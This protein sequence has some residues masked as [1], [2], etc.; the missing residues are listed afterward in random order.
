MH[1][2]LINRSGG[3]SLPRESVVRLTERSDMNFLFTVD[4]KQHNNY[5]IFN[6]QAELFLAI[7]AIAEFI[8][9]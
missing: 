4:V 7:S 2:V 6:L 9:C 3:L 1:E 8:G 5:V